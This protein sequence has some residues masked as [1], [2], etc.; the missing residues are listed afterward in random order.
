MW[1]SRDTR[2]DGAVKEV[3]SWRAALTKRTLIQRQHEDVCPSTGQLERL[4][5]KIEVF[6]IIKYL[7]AMEHSLGEGH[8]DKPHE[9]K[10][11]NIEAASSITSI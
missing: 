1:L 5:N 2:S 10:D 9:V 11:G 7:M 3:W 4:K 8:E 6:F